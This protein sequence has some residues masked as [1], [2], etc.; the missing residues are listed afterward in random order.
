MKKVLY[1]L[2]FVGLIFTSCEDFIEL[3]PTNQISNEIVFTTASDAEAVVLGMYQ[4][5]FQD[6]TRTTY[7]IPGVVSDELVHTG[8]FPTYIELDRNDIASTNGAIFGYWAAVYQGIFMANFLLENIDNIEIDQADYN[9]L[10][11]E[12]LFGRAYLHFKIASLFG[13]TP[14][15]ATTDLAANSEVARSTVAEVNTQILADLNEAIELLAGATYPIPGDEN[16]R[17]TQWSAK[18][19]AARVNL[20]NGDLAAAG[21]FAN[22]VISNGGFSLLPNYNDVF[23]SGGNSESIMKTYFDA[24]DGNAL[25]FFYQEEGRYEYAPS[26]SLVNAYEAGDARFSMIGTHSD[27]R[28]MGVKYTDIQNGSD[29]PILFR[30]AE[31][32]LIR[33]EANLS[34]NPALALA[35]VN[36]IRDR[37]GLA[38]LADVTL[39][40]IL[41]ERFVEFSFEGHRWFDLVRTGRADAVMSALNPSTWSSTDVLMPVPQLEIE[42]NTNL[43]QN[44]GY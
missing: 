30:L 15:V 38:A 24:V 34:S 11:G 32:H 28:P 3:E 25:A 23:T 7:D 4:E 37:A 41:Q 14:I 36:A 17:A 44:P 20:Y 35:D 33:A 40:D 29:Q 6:I 2:L 21:S 22:D 10:R 19:L 16:F 9:R 8:S 26:E 43:T 31:M 27:G 18:A 13:E 5:G 39:D 12:A 1:S 42:R